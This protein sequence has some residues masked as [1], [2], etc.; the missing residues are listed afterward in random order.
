[1]P[2]GPAELPGW[3]VGYDKP[4]R[5]GSAKANIR[6]HE[7]GRVHG[8]VYEVEDGER[9]A[10]DLAE[11]L[12]SP[13]YVDLDDGP[14]VLTYAYEGVP[15]DRPPYDWYVSTALAG[16]AAHGIPANGLVADAFPDPLASGVRAASSA[17]LPLMQDI[18]AEGLQS[19]GARYYVHPGDLAWW[20]YHDDPRHRDR[21]SCW[22]QGESGFVILDSR[23]PHEISLFTR[24][25]VDREPLIDW[26]QRRLGGKGEIGWVS[27]DDEELVLHLKRTGYEPRYAYRSYEWDLS[28]AI[29]EPRLPAGWMVRPVSGEEEADTRRAAAHAAF[30]S[31]MPPAMHLDRY[32]AFMRSPVYVP[33]HDLVVVAPDGT[34]VSFVVW[35]AHDSGIAQIEPF[36]THPDHHRRGAGR[37][38]LHHTLREMSRS[39]MTLA[40]VCTDDDRPA[41]AFY[42]ACGFEDVG[43]LR[44]WA[45]V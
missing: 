5:D 14:R 41:T 35:W 21:F 19:S 29:P 7:R 36:G 11:H 45:P 3:S 24:P 26:S 38:L 10:L 30:E 34:V 42:E 15:H 31:T 33:E 43:R 27:D 17:D 22:I 25:G 16:A 32:L 2:R 39:G 9:Q 40:R 1:M 13:I 12:Y 28:H 37:A 23:E 44:W 4:S 6:P 8:V 18:V 20:E